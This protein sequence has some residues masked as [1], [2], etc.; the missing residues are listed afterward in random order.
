MTVFPKLRAIIEAIK[1][2][3]PDQREII[4]VVGYDGGILSKQ[5]DLLN[6]LPGFVST[7]IQA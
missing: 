4:H 7:T 2:S 3:A 6:H 5:S 1:S